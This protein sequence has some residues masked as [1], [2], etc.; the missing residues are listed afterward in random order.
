MVFIVKMLVVL[1]IPST[2]TVALNLFF[3]EFL[4]SNLKYPVFSAQSGKKVA[5]R[6]VR[7]PSNLNSD[8]EAFNVL[9]PNR[10]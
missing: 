2:V 8:A 4:C 6:S 7:R 9:R 10:T 5:M 1:L 3:K